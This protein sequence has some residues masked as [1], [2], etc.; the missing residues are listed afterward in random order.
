LEFFD[1]KGKR[2][3]NFLKKFGGWLLE[4]KFMMGKIKV[5]KVFVFYLFCQLEPVAGK[6]GY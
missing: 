5:E 3:G 4:K 2:K 1:L 6:K